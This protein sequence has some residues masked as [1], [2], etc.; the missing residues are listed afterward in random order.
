M[1]IDKI[2]KSVLTSNENIDKVMLQCMQFEKKL[3][4][5]IIEIS[6][7]MITQT[8]QTKSQLDKLERRL[9][10]NEEYF[11]S[12]FIVTIIYIYISSLLDMIFISFFLFSYL[13][14]LFLLHHS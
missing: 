9:N 4:S 5:K 8:I 6:D 2:E 11:V 1:H 12:T 7:A 13:I 14:Y 3:D 10:K